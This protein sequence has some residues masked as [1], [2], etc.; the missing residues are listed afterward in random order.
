[1][2][3][4]KAYITMTKKMCRESWGGGGGAYDL[5]VLEDIR[6]QIQEMKQENSI[7]WLMGR[8][9]VSSHKRLFKKRKI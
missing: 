7:Q 5:R 9:P 8:R 6:K 4:I 3:H 2:D 1:M